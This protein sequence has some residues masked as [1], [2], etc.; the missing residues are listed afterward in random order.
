MLVSVTE[1][2]NGSPVIQRLDMNTDGHI[3]TVRHFR[4][5]SQTASTAH[6]NDV[7]SSAERYRKDGSV[8]YSWDLDGDGTLEYSEEIRN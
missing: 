7:F 3:D 2:E 8:V 6:A 5:G 4:S 1:F